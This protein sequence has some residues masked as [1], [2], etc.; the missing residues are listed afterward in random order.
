M[1]FHQDSVR[2]ALKRNYVNYNYISNFFN[3]I[4]LI[5]LQFKIYLTFTL[6]K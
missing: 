5:T 4:K 2:I 1:Y 3:Q 6:Q